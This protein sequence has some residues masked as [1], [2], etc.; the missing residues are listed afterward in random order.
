MGN[1]ASS[2]PA[3]N[4][5]PP[6]QGVTNNAPDPFPPTPQQTAAVNQYD[7]AKADAYHWNDF[8][9]NRDSTGV[10]LGSHDF[11]PSEMDLISDCVSKMQNDL[12]V[13]QQNFANMSMVDQV[14]EDPS[15]GSVH[16]GVY[17]ETSAK[18]TIQGDIDKWHNAWATN[19]R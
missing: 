11:G 12:N 15:T 19:T 10:L 1:G 8:L 18:S 14:T 7:A 2:F 6:Q 5:G 16:L 13:M 9:E 3:P 17:T 4:Q